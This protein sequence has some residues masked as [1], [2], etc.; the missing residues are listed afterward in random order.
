MFV[1][2]CLGREKDVTVVATGVVCLCSTIRNGESPVLRLKTYETARSQSRQ[3]P[4]AISL[5]IKHCYV[6]WQDANCPIRLVENDEKESKE[7]FF[8]DKAAALH[9]MRISQSY[10][11]PENCLIG[12]K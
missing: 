12:G 8:D 11:L 2:A 3:K 5:R 10:A 7:L 1:L 4:V 9:K 6:R